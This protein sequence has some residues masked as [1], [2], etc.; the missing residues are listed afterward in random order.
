MQF[1]TR[2]FNG[3]SRQGR[4]WIL[5]AVFILGW[6]VVL[7]RLAYLQIV[8]LE[9]YRQ[10]A[11]TQHG[12]QAVLAPIR[13]EIKLQGSTFGEVVTAATTIE[14]PLVYALPP[15]IQD[16][17]AAAK[18][19]EPILEISTE[20]LE[21]KLKELKKRYIILRKN[22]SEEQVEKIKALKLAG[23]GIEGE[24]TR[25]YPYGDFLSSTLG[26]VG[27]DAESGSEKKGLYGLERA[28]NDTLKGKA[29]R[30]AQEKSSVSNAWIFGGRRDFQ[31]S[32]NG[33]TL[34][35]TINLAA[36]R[37]VEDV[38]RK[39]V[40]KHGA[41]RGCAIVLDPHTGA[42]ISMASFP[43]F[44]PNAYNK[45]N[46]PGVYNNLCTT[47]SYE[48]GSVMKAV[49]MAAALDSGKV[50]PDTTYEDTGQVKLDN[51]TIKNSDGKAHGKRT[52]TQ[53]LEES[54]NTG[55]I[56]AQNELGDAGFIKA[57]QDFGFGSKTGVEVAEAAGDLRNLNTGGPVHF[58]TASF[59]QGISVTPL[60]MAV[61]YAVLANGGRLV[62]PFLVQSRV[63]AEGQSHDTQVQLGEPILK[64]ETHSQIT[65]MLVSVVENGHGKRA[66]VPGFSVAGKTGT[67]QVA[68][69]G[70]RGYDPDNTIGTF[71]GF[72]PA[73]NP[74]FVVLVRIDHPRDVQFAE[75]TAAP[76]FGEIMRF[77]LDK[78]NIVPD[79]S[80][81]GAK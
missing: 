25:F 23:I 59:G 65:G 37:Q 53:V 79:R 57:V 42:I 64:P 71:V 56:F 62:K 61:S 2:G 24:P 26:F 20:D 67:A 4:L 43:S 77:L 6:C 58:A 38:L 10:L 35:L 68:I 50:T 9:Y 33:E 22:L 52:M 46:N 29:G 15:Q 72:A 63:D 44:D 73:F 17:G 36:Q 5:C 70:Q 49:T 1:S 80:V 76:A 31:P 18:L 47:G 7:G 48:P 28:L 51:F 27:F 74:K 78:W 75:S 3:P 16:V 69:P 45:A 30:L 8:S 13:G 32:E 14:K 11:A 54:L 21:G 40:E 19:L 39:T 12:G 55:V 81:G 66:K 34:L 60:Q 41:D